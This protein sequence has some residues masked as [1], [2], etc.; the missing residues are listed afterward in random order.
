MNSCVCIFFVQVGEAKH[1]SYFPPQ[2]AREA[3]AEREYNNSHRKG[4]REKKIKGFSNC[5]AWKG[6]KNTE[7]GGKEGMDW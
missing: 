2:S 4:Q 5:T 1:R 7:C 3:Q 6:S